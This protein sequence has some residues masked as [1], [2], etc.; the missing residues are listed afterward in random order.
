MNDADLGDTIDQ[1]VGPLESN[2]PREN[3]FE[4]DEA[5]LDPR[6]ALPLPMLPAT[7]PKSTLWTNYV[8]CHSRWW[9]ASSAFPMIAGTLGP[10]ASA[11]SICALVR[12]WRQSFL[13]GQDIE[14]APFIDDP[15]WYAGIYLPAAWPLLIRVQVA[16]CQ[17]Y[18]IGGSRRVEYLPP[19][20]HDEE[21]TVL[22]C[23]T[24]HNCRM[25]RWPSLRITYRGNNCY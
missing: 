13:P 23:S 21:T 6:S 1:H 3:R 22:S 18:P 7:T 20:E 8:S 25:V 15:S 12:P 24:D 16:D 19:A 5:H 2:I 17:C 10:V 9:F 11:F 14:T 4:N